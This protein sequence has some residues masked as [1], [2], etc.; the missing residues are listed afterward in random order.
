MDRSVHSECSNL[1]RERKE[2]TEVVFIL[3][4]TVLIGGFE[5]IDNSHSNLLSRLRKGRANYE[6]RNG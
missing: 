2:G 3:Q 1:A 5:S 6:A 4:I